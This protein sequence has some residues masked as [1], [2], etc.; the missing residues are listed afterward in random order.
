MITRIAAEA[1]SR[2]AAGHFPPRIINP[3]VKPRVAERYAAALGRP[4][5]D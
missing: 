3:A 5:T 4:I 2:F 1:F